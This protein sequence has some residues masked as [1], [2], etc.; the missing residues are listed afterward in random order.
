MRPI[1]PTM[2]TLTRDSDASTGSPKIASGEPGSSG[3]S[4][5]PNITPAR[6][7]T[8]Q[9]WQ[10]EW[11]RILIVNAPSRMNPVAAS[12]LAWTEPSWKPS[13]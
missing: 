4:F 11:R 8:E 1:T 12:A 6:D 13:A 10:P 2:R 3:A 9:R 7:V 5:G